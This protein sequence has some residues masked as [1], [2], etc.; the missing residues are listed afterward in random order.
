MNVVFIFIFFSCPWSPPSAA[1]SQVKPGLVLFL[2]KR[3]DPLLCSDGPFH[4]PETC[5]RAPE[6]FLQCNPS[7]DTR[8]PPHSPPSM[9]LVSRLGDWTLYIDSRVSNPAPIPPL[10]SPA[11]Q[12]RKTLPCLLPS[13]WGKVPCYDEWTHC[14]GR[15]ENCTPTFSY[16][17][18]GKRGSCT[19]FPH[20]G[21]WHGQDFW[22]GWAFLVKQERN[23]QRSDLF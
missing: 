14:W 10:A 23:L 20:L 7:L 16:P 13:S 1:H 17:L 6:V 9:H 19:I 2:R 8:R 15:V 11:S 5:M 4:S 12:M 22:G 21:G 3:M 18:W